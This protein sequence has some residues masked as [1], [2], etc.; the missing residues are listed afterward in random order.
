VRT[1]ADFHGKKW[2]ESVIF[3][4][5]HVYAF[6]K[7]HLLFKVSILGTEYDIAFIQDYS[8]VPPILSE[9]DLD[10]GFLCLRLENLPGSTRFISPKGFVCAAFIVD[11]GDN[12]IDRYCL[13]DFVDNDMYLRLNE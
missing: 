6:A 11:T 5:H 2:E 8:I 12:R 3:K 1:H 4:N 9:D 7:V 13:N 10:A